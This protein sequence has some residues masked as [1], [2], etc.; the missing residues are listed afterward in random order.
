MGYT[1][2]Q[3]QKR[4]HTNAQWATI[5][6]DVAAILKDVQH[7]QNIPLADGSGE[8]GTQPELGPDHIWFNGPGEDAHE[9]FV[10]NRLVAPLEDWMGKDRRGWSFCKT[11]RKPYDLAVTACLCY[12][13][14]V[15]GTHSVT[16]DGTGHDWLAGLQCARRALPQYANILDIPRGILEN[17]RWTSG[18]PYM[19]TYMMQEAYMFALCVDGHG[20]VVRNKD[21]A[22]YCFPDH[23]EARAWAEKNAAVIAPT[24]HFDEKR[25]TSLARQQTVLLKQLVEAAPVLRRDQRPPAFVRPR[26]MPQVEQPMVTF[27]EMFDLVLAA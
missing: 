2:Y 19:R 3:T 12:L 26:A 4:R 22:A 1:H 24:G 23:D 25:R 14:T 21:G 7:V 13:E 15:I 27:E 10:I 8:P 6:T 5:L 9:T 16:S 17:D 20:Y 18:K 11:A